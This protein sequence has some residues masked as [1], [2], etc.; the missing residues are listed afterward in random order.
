MTT[1]FESKILVYHDIWEKNTA[2]CFLSSP[3][4]F[5]ILYCRT[6]FCLLFTAF[7]V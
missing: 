7:N 3:T 2:I 6:S 5:L 1:R 4:P